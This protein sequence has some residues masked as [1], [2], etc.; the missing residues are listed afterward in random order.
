[1]N[2]NNLGKKV[3]SEAI[4]SFGGMSAGSVFRYLFS[5]L[6]ARWLGPYWL[7][8]YSIGNAVTR[9]GEIFGIMGLDNG[10]L[11]YVS[12]EKEKN[13]KVK[14][15]IYSS[16][17]MGFVSSIFVGILIY[18]S[19][20]WIAF[21]F[22][23]VFIGITQ[24]PFIEISFLPTVIKV[25][26]ATLPFTVTTLI[27][28]FAT[29]GFKILKYKVF[30]NQIVNPFTLLLTMMFSYIFFGTKIAILAP[31]VFSAIIGFFLILFYLKRFVNIS[32]KKVINAK[33]DTKILK[34][35]LPLMFVSAIGIIMHW[36][37]VFMISIIKDP[38]AVGMYH[39]I[40]RTAGLIR[41]ILFA[42]A[43]IFAPLFSQYFYQNNS[44]KMKEIYQLSTKWIFAVS[45]P[46]FIFLII[47]S[48]E[49]LMLFGNEF[50][51]ELALR[52]LAT[53]IMI[54]AFFGLGSS[55][56]SMSGFSNV[57]L[58]NVLVAL[59]VNIVMNI[60]LIPEHGII[61]AAFGTAI[62][63]FFISFLRFFENY[64]ILNLN[65]FSLKLLKPFFAGA[66]T[67][68][69]AILFD[70]HVFILFDYSSSILNL[71][72]YLLSAICT[73]LILYF[74]FYILLGLDE[75]DRDMIDSLKQKI[76]NQS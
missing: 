11:R 50:D 23:N 54:Q 42:F 45:L 62:A 20:N 21:R 53:G 65:I 29:Q 75:E 64:Y 31:T 28:S 39:P 14:N 37:D 19:S 76:L 10:V 69:S 41:M 48:S 15:S 6:M 33:I 57:N 60:I 12:R 32:I 52:I 55:S 22:D 67:A 27:A 72:L 8:I 46:L 61:G 44:E 70:E 68:V 7:G 36:I 59:I 58:F 9:I 18:F 4:T 49:M 5:I 34:F 40:E 38:S 26:A 13:N 17:K 73:I 2:Q 16:I 56:L 74:S 63:L 25:Y 24:F 43:G 47:F 30:V 3:A 35:S 51:N 71:S 1:M 66:L